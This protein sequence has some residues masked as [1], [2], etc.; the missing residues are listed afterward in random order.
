MAIQ[1]NAP[2]NFLFPKKILFL[3]FLNCISFVNVVLVMEIFG[4][5][6]PGRFG[7]IYPDLGRDVFPMHPLAFLT[8][9]ISL[10]IF[11]ITFMTELGENG[12]T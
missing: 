6:F 10:F 11:Y 1:G 3:F 4:G 2:D 7:S 8:A 5:K 12:S 9:P